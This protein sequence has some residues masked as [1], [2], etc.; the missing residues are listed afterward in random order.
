MICTCKSICTI[1]IWD[2]L[3][4]H[5]VLT[6]SKGD[7]RHYSTFILLARAMNHTW[8]WT[9][10][11]YEI[12]LSLSISGL[13]IRILLVACNLQC[14]Y[15]MTEKMNSH[16]EWNL[17]LKFYSKYEIYNL[18]L[19]KTKKDSFL[20]KATRDIVN[21][22][23][24]CTVILNSCSLFNQLICCIFFL[25]FFQFSPCLQSKQIC[26]S[27]I[28]IVALLLGVTFSHY[29]VV[30]HDECLHMQLWIVFKYIFFL[31]FLFINNTRT[32]MLSFFSRWPSTRFTST[33]CRMLF[34][35]MEGGF[36]KGKKNKYG[37]ILLCCPIHF[38]W[39]LYSRYLKEI[40]FCGFRRFWPNPRT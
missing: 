31:S 2:D 9:Y 38:H 26:C 5:K 8:W 24:V 1:W 40:N 32:A 13:V 28:K 36:L 39:I 29:T 34:E 14:I 11:C 27:W 22:Y 18:Y 4:R 19:L 35:Y 6:W 23:G 10:A 3:T 21:V 25:L 37:W 16:C 12:F 7:Q 33:R 15:R 17:R 30:L 20:Y